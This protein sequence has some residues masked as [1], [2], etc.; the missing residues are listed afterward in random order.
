MLGAEQ[1]TSAFQT[2]II[3]SHEYDQT[4]SPTAVVPKILP[5]WWSPKCLR[6]SNFCKSPY[7]DNHISI[8]E[9]RESTNQRDAINIARHTYLSVPNSYDCI[10]AASPDLAIVILEAV[11][12]GLMTAL[13]F[14]HQLVRL[15]G[16][17]HHHSSALFNYNAG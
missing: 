14:S 12:L 5:W 9:A 11:Q 6:Q 7:P 8:A 1:R 13:K 15:S 10:V 3:R 2:L 17:H 16:I 4:C